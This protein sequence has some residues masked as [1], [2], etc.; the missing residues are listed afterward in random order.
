MVASER[1]NLGPWPVRP[2]AVSTRAEL[3]AAF[4]YLALWTLGLAAKSWNHQAVARRWCDAAP[5]CAASAQHLAELYEEARYTIGAE[6]LPEALRE[7][8]RQSLVRLA[9]AI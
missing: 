7:R 5:A 6:E 8:A 3:I 2:E 4:D 9:E 1:P